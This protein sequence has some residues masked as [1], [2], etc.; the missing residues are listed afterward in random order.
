MESRTKA[1]VLFSGGLDSLIAIK[2]LEHQGIEVTGFCFTSNFFNSANAEK[3]AKENNVSLRLVDI[4]ADILELVKNPPSGYGKNL[5]PCIDCHSL[6]IR[7]AGEI[8]KSE[9]Y[10]FIAT[11][12]VLGQRP[13]SQN[14]IALDRVRKLGEAEI[15][16]PLS[17]K[18]LKETE[19]EKR[20]LVKRN[21]L[22]SISGRIREKQIELAE[23][24]N[25]IYPSPGG[26]CL[27]TDPSFCERMMKMLE[28]WPDCQPEDVELLKNGRVF[29]LNCQG[30]RVFSVVGRD[31]SENNSLEKLAK[32]GDFMIE[33]KDKNGP[34]TLIRGIRIN[35]FAG[36]E[37]RTD[38]PSNINKI[39]LDIGRNY[40]FEEIIE[41]ESK[42]T[43]Y[44]A[45]KLRGEKVAINIRRI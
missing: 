32:K 14:K 20:G 44:H 21:L 7:K 37:S 10:D 16:R 11:G 5:N 39:L 1:I 23:N 34:S 15:L 35:S 27:L 41:I 31:E 18:L 43:G 30:R 4:S 9:G 33:L 12:E 42:L 24:M 8:M 26:G 22:L 28:Y 29:W 19:I 17:A 25:L 3:S 2:I 40:S 6:M 36:G 38:I 45:P 13:F